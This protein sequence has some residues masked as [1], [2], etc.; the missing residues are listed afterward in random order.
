[1]TTKSKSTRDSEFSIIQ[2]L[3]EAGEL[4]LEKSDNRPLRDLQR[5]I[6][7]WKESVSSTKESSICYLMFFLEVFIDRVFYNLSGDVPYVKGITEEIQND[8]YKTIGRILQDIGNNLKDG[9]NDQINV[10]FAEMAKTYY[11]TVELLNKSL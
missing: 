9:N 7:N 8:F 3:E 5:S 1:V 4:L 10:C 2:A 6:W 11:N